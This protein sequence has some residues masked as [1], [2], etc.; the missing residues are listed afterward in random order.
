M[1]LSALTETEMVPPLLLDFDAASDAP[2]PNSEH[3][4]TSITISFDTDFIILPPKLIDQ[5]YVRI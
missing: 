1:L 3:A 5:S 4:A 2:N